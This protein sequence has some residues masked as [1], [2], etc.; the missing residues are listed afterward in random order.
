ALE[1][2]SD[3]VKETLIGVVRPIEKGNAQEIWCSSV[4]TSGNARCEALVGAILGASASAR[5]ATATT[6]DAT[7]APTNAASIA[8]AGGANVF[9][10]SIT[11]PSTCALTKRDDGADAACQDGSRLSWR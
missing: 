4:D 1:P 10:R 2:G 9:G 11:L 7:T 6:T 3:V 8:S 5:V